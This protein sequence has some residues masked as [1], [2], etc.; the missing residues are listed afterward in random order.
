MI[1]NELLL[2]SSV[3][4]K[5]TLTFKAYNAEKSQVKLSIYGD[6]A[7]TGKNF[8][9]SLDAIPV[10]HTSTIIEADE[11]F[12]NIYVTVQLCG[13]YSVY[14]ESHSSNITVLSSTGCDI[15]YS[16]DNTAS[17]KDIIIAVNVFN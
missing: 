11:P 15:E 4:T 10:A 1:N 16:V 6:L 14:P 7:I 13:K 8:D 2:S 17:N 9:A 5:Y 3:A 12:A